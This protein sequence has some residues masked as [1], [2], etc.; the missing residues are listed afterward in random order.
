M[1]IL[2]F[3]LIGFSSVSFSAPRLTVKFTEILTLYKQGDYVQALEKLKPLKRNSKLRPLAHYWAGLC[4][5]G[6]QEY[7]LAIKEFSTA[8][9]LKVDAKDMYYEYGQALYANQELRKARKAFKNSY[10]KRYKRATSLYYMGFISQTLEQYPL[11]QK[12]Y[13]L[14]EELNDADTQVKQSGSFQLAEIWTH[15]IEKGK[16]KKLK[17]NAIKSN[18]LPQ[19]DKAISTDTSSNIV[20]DI[21]KRKRDLILKYD[22]GPGRWVNGRQIRPRPLSIYVR[23]EIDQNSNVILESSD[24][25]QRAQQKDSLVYTTT[26]FVSYQFIHKRKIGLVPELR[27]SFVKHAEDSPDIFQNDSYTIAPALRANIEHYVGKIPGSLL[28]DFEYDYT[29]R[30]RER[31]KDKILFGRTTAFSIGERWKLFSVGDTTLRFRLRK[32]EAAQSANDSTTRSLIFTQ[33]YFLP[34]KDLMIFLFNGDWM[35]NNTEANSTN[36]YL[37]RLDYIA[38]KLFLGVNANLGLSYSL[39]DTKLQKP[40]RGTEKSWSP[41]LRFTKNIF[42]RSNISLTYSYTDKDSKRRSEYAYEQHIYGIEFE[43]R[44]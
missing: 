35:D 6:L 11:A 38:P 36:N 1:K 26:G 32:F 25:T 41:S 7:D 15:Q 20:I 22:L 14:L 21:K 40:Q 42:K 29:A 43:L 3:L 28:I 23:Q 31:K 37:F 8:E 30:D 13:R 12:Y 4:Q 16:G 34:N 24:A 33:T 5:N 27:M 18:V 19:L 44:N 2:L 39:T 10:A 9:K 17:S